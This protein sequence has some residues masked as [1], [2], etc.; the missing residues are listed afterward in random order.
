[1]AI[2]QDDPLKDHLLS[3]LE[4][5]NLELASGQITQLLAFIDLLHKWNKAYNLTAIRDPN[6]MIALHLLDSLAI[7]PYLQGERIIDVGTGAG[8]PGLP[9]AICN[10]ERYFVLLDSNGKKTRFVQQAVLELGIANVTVK[11]ERAETY[12]PMD[13]FDTVVCR[14]FSDMPDI[15]AM[16]KHLM[17]DQG[18]ILA[19]KGQYPE[20]ELALLKQEYKVY[21]LEVP[22]INAERCLIQLNS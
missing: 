19:M 9:L 10:Q 5:L 7:L 14:A 6:A 17:A 2:L 16:T 1:M 22:G 3:G 20:N 21:T 11:H 18:C 8:L 12:H 13:G 15:I 4:A